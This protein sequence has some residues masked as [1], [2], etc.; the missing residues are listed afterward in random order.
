MMKLRRKWKIVDFLLVLVL[1]LLENE[2]NAAILILKKKRHCGFS[3]RSM[4]ENGSKEGGKEK[5]KKALDL[6][7]SN[8]NL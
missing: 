6:G 5:A 4:A 1:F 2:S 3:D 8:K 7:Q